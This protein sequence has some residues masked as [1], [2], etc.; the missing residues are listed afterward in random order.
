[1]IAGSV[2]GG[3]LQRKRAG[4]EL[5]K[6]DLFGK[7]VDFGGEG[8]VQQPVRGHLVLFFERHRGRLHGLALAVLDLHAD[9]RQRR[10]RPHR[11]VDGER[12]PFRDRRL[13]ARKREVLRLREGDRFSRFARVHRDRRLARSGQ[14]RQ[15]HQNGQQQQ[16]S[17]FHTVL[18]RQYSMRCGNIQYIT[19]YAKKQA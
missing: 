7:A 8:R 1:M 15:Q 19:E 3:E 10:G 17:A 16:Y 14:R 13:R 9:A 12:T 5:V 11:A 2:V 6:A 18:P 4:W